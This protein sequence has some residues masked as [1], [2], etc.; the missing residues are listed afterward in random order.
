MQVDGQN[1]SSF[2]SEI[3]YCIVDCIVLSNNPLNATCTI[4]NYLTNT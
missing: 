2:F 4:N 3:I 1:R